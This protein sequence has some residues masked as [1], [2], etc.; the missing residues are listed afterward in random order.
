MDKAIIKLEEGT[1]C[2]AWNY[3]GHRLAAGST[4]GTLFVFDS[5]DPASSVFSGSSKFKVR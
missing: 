2:T 3:S 1:T 5:T 4:D